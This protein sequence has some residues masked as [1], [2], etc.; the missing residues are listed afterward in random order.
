M[1]LPFDIKYPA[2]HILQE[3][4]PS[5]KHYKQFESK[6]FKQVEVIEFILINS[7]LYPL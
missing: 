4:G 1:H 7:T 6:H 5:S 3:T 2:T